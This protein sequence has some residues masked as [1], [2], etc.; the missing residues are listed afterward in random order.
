MGII[1]IKVVEGDEEV[2]LVKIWKEE[3]RYYLS[4]LI[5]LNRR[6]VWSRNF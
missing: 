1:Y 6:R 5:F 4:S 3:R 2:F